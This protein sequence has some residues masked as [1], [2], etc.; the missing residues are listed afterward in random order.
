MSRDPS[1]RLVVM[2]TLCWHP[3]LHSLVV[4]FSVKGG[5]CVERGGI[6]DPPFFWQ[7]VKSALDASFAP[8]MLGMDLPVRRIHLDVAGLSPCRRTSVMAQM[9][10]LIHEL[11]GALT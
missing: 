3:S 4:S 8:V 9:F 1:S 10:S 6:R 7:F 2:A 5:R 11:T